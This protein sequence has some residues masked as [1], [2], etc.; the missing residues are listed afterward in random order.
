MEDINRRSALNLG[1][2]AAAA[3]PLLAFTTP[4]VAGA[5]MYGPNDGVAIGPGQRMVEV[6]EMESQITAYK[7]VKIIDIIY[8]PGAADAAD[9][10]VMDTDMVCHIIAGEFTIQKKGIPAYTVKE[11]DIYT[12]GKGK[13]DM[14]TNISKVIGIHRIALLIPA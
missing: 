14:A 1:L 10:P 9:S 5:P 13:S 3:T 11:G 12:C 7:S 2:A 4:A 8:Q 6:G